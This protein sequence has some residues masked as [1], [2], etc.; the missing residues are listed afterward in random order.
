[1]KRPSKNAWFEKQMCGPLV[2]YFTVHDDDANDVCVEWCICPDDEDKS[3][4]RAFA[5][6][7]HDIR[8]PA[9]ELDALIDRAVK[10]A[11]AAATH[12]AREILAWAQGDLD[13]QAQEAT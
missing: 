9:R 13:Q 11:A 4:E 10:E 2:V 12:I 3:E 1:M 6:S 7:D 8:G 5:G